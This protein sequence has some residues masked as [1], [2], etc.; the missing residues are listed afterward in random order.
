MGAWAVHRTVSST[1]KALMERKAPGV[2]AF[3]AALIYSTGVKGKD[4][5][6]HLGPGV[7]VTSPAGEGVPGVIVAHPVSVSG[8]EGI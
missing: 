1:K 5:V 3:K 7:G 8:E 6:A 4:V 2:V